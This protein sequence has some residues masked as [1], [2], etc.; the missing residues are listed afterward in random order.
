MMGTP[1]NLPIA[2]VTLFAGLLSSSAA[3]AQTTT[4]P[5]STY[6]S[7]IAEEA[8]PSVQLEYNT[9]T[10][11]GDLWPSCWASDGNLY[12]ANGDGVAFNGTSQSTVYDL[13]VSRISG[14]IASGLQGVTVSSEIVPALDNP[15]SASGSIGLNY[16]GNNSAYNDKPTGMLCLGGSLF[17]AYE[18]LATSAGNFSGAPAASVLQSTDFGQTW[19]T[20]PATPM[21]GSSNPETPGVLPP[22]FPRYGPGQAKQ[23]TCIRLSLWT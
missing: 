22:F 10:Q 11:I 23:A 18:N 6:F 5:Q 16:T 7:G 2:S 9:Q 15:P 13:A 19:S 12:A 20:P 14:T 3:L 1:G 21:F 17:L 4:P 8:T